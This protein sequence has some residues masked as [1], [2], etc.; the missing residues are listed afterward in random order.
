MATAT[1]PANPGPLTRFKTWLAEMD[2]KKSQ[3]EN[4]VAR[5]SGREF[6]AGVAGVAIVIVLLMMVAWSNG[7]SAGVTALPYAANGNATNTG[8]STATTTTTTTGSDSSG[9][10]SSGAGS[11]H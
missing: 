8:G 6:Y 5:W 4:P 2:A 11:G 1:G 9:G 3:L 7:E 10:A